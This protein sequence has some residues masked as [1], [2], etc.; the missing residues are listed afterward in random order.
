M[1]VAGIRH[2]VRLFV[3]SV[4]YHPSRFTGALPE[5]CNSIQSENAPSSS[6]NPVSFRAMN[7]EITTDSAPKVFRVRMPKRQRSKNLAMIRRELLTC[8]KQQ[9]YWR[10]AGKRQTF[11]ET[12][13]SFVRSPGFSPSRSAGEIAAFRQAKA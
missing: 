13:S 12:R 11:E 2:F 8:W 3:V 6:R 1:F 5:L 9:E 4:R 7:S 10:N